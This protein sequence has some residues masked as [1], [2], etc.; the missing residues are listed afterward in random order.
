MQLLSKYIQSFRG[1]NRNVWTIA[2]VLLINRAGSMV[3]AF[4][5]LYFITELHFSKTVA[6]YVMSCFG[7]GSILGS[8]LGGYLA[9]RFNQKIIMTSSLVLSGFTLLSILYTTNP[10]SISIIIF[11]YALL[12][13]AFRPSSSAQISA[14]ST[15]INRTRSITLMRLAINLGLAIGPAVGG[16]VAY[17]FGYKNLFIIDAFT[18]FGAAIYLWLAFEPNKQ[19]KNTEN[20]DL[21]SVKS[22]SAYRDSHFLIFILLVA[23]YGICFFQLINLVPNYF[24][25]VYH[26]NEKLIGYLFALN[27]LIVVVAEMP[28]V[29]WLDHKKIPFTLIALGCFCISVALSILYFNQG[30]II[31]SSAFV[32]IFTLSEILAMPYMMNITLQRAPKDRQGQYSALYSVS[33]GIALA[34]APSVGLGLA[35]R[36]GFQWALMFFVLLSITLAFV[37]F[38]YRYILKVK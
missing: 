38:H 16:Y 24:K 4:C 5:T 12:S 30:N 14:N 23:C 33:Y 36:I 7:I 32:V 31:W 20:S 25:E 3:L 15:D 22:I 10:W 37:F 9:D 34:L 18:S 11:C 35:D 19:K 29:A 17:E 1:I 26:Y 6:G 27:C 13:D 28:M 2:S 21:S 8:L